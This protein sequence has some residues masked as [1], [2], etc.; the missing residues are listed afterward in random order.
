MSASPNAI[1]PINPAMMVNTVTGAA[2]AN[3]PA[4]LPPEEDPAIQAQI[5]ADQAKEQ[6]RLQQQTQRDQK[7]ALQI[8]KMT[9]DNLAKRMDRIAKTAPSPLAHVTAGMDTV[10]KQILKTTSRSGHRKFAADWPTGLGGNY[11]YQAPRQPAGRPAN[12]TV[13][14]QPDVP[15]LAS[16]VRDYF[17]DP[18]GETENVFSYAGPQWWKE[19]SDSI[20]NSMTEPT[21]QKY[22]EG[23]L[24][25][26]AVNA[27]S[28]LVGQF[29]KPLLWGAQA[30]PR[31]L[32]RGIAVPFTEAAMGAGRLVKKIGQNGLYTKI[33]YDGDLRKPL[34]GA[35]NLAFLGNPASAALS[36]GSSTFDT[37][38]PQLSG[39]FDTV[40]NALGF[41]AQSAP[42]PPPAQD[43]SGLFSAITGMLGQAGN[44]VKNIAGGAMS[45]LSSS[46]GPHSTSHFNNLI[47]GPP[48]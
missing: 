34:T 15:G 31:A 24:A 29:N 5:A 9:E 4:P 30:V 17:N 3:Q 18:S 14:G 48:A 23:S 41:G 35:A 25:S 19:K 27:A 2:S 1:K 38:K 16:Y 28:G 46:R 42:A 7:H 45:A 8:E 32:T 11:G 10:R 44:S 40:K 13:S 12:P 22:G 6:Q 37:L 21:K 39:A 43:M 20:Y 26:H 36:L 47:Y 33:D